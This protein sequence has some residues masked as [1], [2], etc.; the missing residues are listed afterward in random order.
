MEGLYAEGLATQAA[1]SHASTT[2]EGVANRAAH[3]SPLPVR[4]AAIT[5]TTRSPKVI[6]NHAVL[7]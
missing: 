2:C 1:P 6:R 7:A 4:V 3:A 5:I